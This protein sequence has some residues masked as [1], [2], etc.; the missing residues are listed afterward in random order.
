MDICIDLFVEGCEVNELFSTP[1]MSRVLC[2]MS[3]IDLVKT[4]LCNINAAFVI[5]IGY[6]GYMG[7]FALYCSLNAIPVGTGFQ[8]ISNVYQSDSQTDMR[9]YSYLKM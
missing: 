1:H 7:V 3:I 5:C 9:W 6:M 2:G 4:C 8:K